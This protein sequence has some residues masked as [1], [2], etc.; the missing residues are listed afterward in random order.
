LFIILT[1]EVSKL[2]LSI[3]LIRF[4]VIN[5]IPNNNKKGR[6]Q[7]S[8]G[9]PQTN[10]LGMINSN[11]K[12]NNQRQKANQI[13][14]QPSAI[15]TKKAMKA[16][17]INYN[18]NGSC[19]ISHREYLFD[20]T[21]TNAFASTKVSINAG[22][23]DSFPW[24]SAIA[25]RFESYLFHRLQFE[26]CTESP[27]NEVGTVLLTV[28]Y[29]PLDPAP[30]SKTQALAYVDAVRS[31]PWSDCC[32]V[33]STRDLHK[34]TTYFTRSIVSD[35]TDLTTKDVG[36]LFVCTQGQANNRTLGEIWVSYEVELMT[37][38]L[39]EVATLYQAVSTTPLAVSNPSQFQAL[40]QSLPQEEYGTAAPG[41][42]NNLGEF[43]FQAKGRFLLTLL[44]NIVNGD[45]DDIFVNVSTNLNM[46]FTNVSIVA[47]TA[48]DVSGNAGPSTPTEIQY[49]T[50]IDVIP[51][52]NFR[53]FAD[54]LISDTG[55]SA[56]TG[57]FLISIP[58]DFVKLNDYIRT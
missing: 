55:V 14:V 17:R 40:F 46:H 21:G 37:P 45:E 16:P 11:S 27:T 44:T 33:A 34:R 57:I 19:R 42:W 18:P 12:Q 5:W 52:S 58:K 1:W 10:P 35:T 56:T 26:F 3:S 43:T 29:D 8:K 49:S 53:P 41:G 54:V 36:N 7:K 31:P 9:G 47:E 38:Q 15:A 6:K 50:I 23:S 32:F 48:N 30:S 20:I 13:V 2:I 4:I 28:D 51:G 22:L 24:L 25:N 39:I